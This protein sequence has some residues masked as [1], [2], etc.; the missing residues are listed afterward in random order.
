VS[1][2]SVFAAG[3]DPVRLYAAGSLRAAMADLAAAFGKREGIAVAVECGCSGLLRLRIE[4]GEPAE[5]FASADMG[6]PQ[7]LAAA[8]RAAFA[9]PFARNRLCAL[10]RPGVK[11]TSETLLERMLDPSIK[12]A[13]STP[14]SD[15]SGDYA[16]LAFEK[17]ER[18]RPGAYKLLDAKAMKLVGGPDS[19]PPPKDRTAHGKYLEDNAADLFLTYSTNAVLAAREVP[20][21]QIVQL[22][23]E[24]SVAAEYGLALIKG[25]RP[26]AERFSVFILSPQ[27]QAM[28]AKH[29]FSPPR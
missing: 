9:R 23:P 13:T 6:H 5:L 28:L 12:L 21:L 2:T 8:G 3:A 11:A 22:P 4:D 20:S 10:A 29:G 7:K 1:A 14:E 19:P 16:W 25:A 27:G 17:A 24:L 26:E 15:P 18:I